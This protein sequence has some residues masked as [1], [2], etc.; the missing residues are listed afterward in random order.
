MISSVLGHRE[1]PAILYPHVEGSGMSIPVSIVGEEERDTGFK[2]VELG[3]LV[4]NGNL[5]IGLGSMKGNVS[6]WKSS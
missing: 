2:I 6:L 4:Q 5:Q 3:P 1:F